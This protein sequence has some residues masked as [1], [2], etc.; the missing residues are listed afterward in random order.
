M[1]LNRQIALV[2]MPP[3]F[4]MVLHA[5]YGTAVGWDGAVIPVVLTSLMAV[6]SVTLSYF[7]AQPLRKKMSSLS[8]TAKTISA[9]PE[10]N[11]S[12]DKSGNTA[13]DEI[14]RALKSAVRHQ[15][16]MEKSG[17][18]ALFKSTAFEGSSVAMMMIDRDFTVTYV[19][20][21]TKKLLGDNADVFQIGRAHV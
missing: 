16:H 1:N 12:A 20:E 5:I 4:F 9:S 15:E 8:N 10:K 2:A 21:S 6:V 18:E 11:E 13:L 7:L 14:T 17:R 19:N 3:L